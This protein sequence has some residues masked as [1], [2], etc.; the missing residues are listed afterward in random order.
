MN[1]FVLVGD[2]LLLREVYRA[3]CCE[4]CDHVI[5]RH[6][7]DDPTFYG[8]A[9]ESKP[10]EDQEDVSMGLMSDRRWW[11]RNATSAGFTCPLHRFP[12]NL[13][14]MKGYAARRKEIGIVEEDEGD[15]DDEH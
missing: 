6:P 8:C 15:D 7:R 14:H 12:E 4:F 11:D 1:N 9:V 2:E 3:K 5:E 13:P 10:Q